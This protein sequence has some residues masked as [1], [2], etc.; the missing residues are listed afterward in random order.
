MVDL[1][2]MT[3]PFFLLSCLDEALFLEAR[4]NLRDVRLAR[5]FRYIEFRPDRSTKIGHR[6]RLL[7]QIPDL[8]ASALE[9]EIERTVQVENGDLVIDLA[10]NLTGRS[11]ENGGLKH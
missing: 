2:V 10:G 7:E 6:S 9:T 3:R 11:L 8:D 1:S 4:E 5:G